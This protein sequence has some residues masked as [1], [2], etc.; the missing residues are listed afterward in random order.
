MKSKAIDSTKHD[1]G[2]GAKNACEASDGDDF[3]GS[4]YKDA[5]WGIDYQDLVAEL[6]VLAVILE[7]QLTQHD[8][9]LGIQQVDQLCRFA[10]EP[11]PRAGCVISTA[12]R[13]SLALRPSLAASHR[14]SFVDG[15]RGRAPT[16]LS[17]GQQHDR[18]GNPFCFVLQD[19]KIH[20]QWLKL[21]KNVNAPK[22]FKLSVMNFVDFF[23]SDFGN[24]I[25][26]KGTACSGMN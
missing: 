20:K 5:S 2:W 21:K 3:S 25:E 8:C 13:K 10:Q 4:C 6:T 9:L 18:L 11:S 24:V 23:V 15:T 17:S 26:N 1:I 16:S 19:K 12:Q 7:S 14:V 22:T